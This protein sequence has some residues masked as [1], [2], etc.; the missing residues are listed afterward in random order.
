M[1]RTGFLL[2][3]RCSIDESERAASWGPPQGKRVRR[4]REELGLSDGELGEQVGLSG[5]T[6]YYYEIGLI[7]P[8]S[9]L[10]SIAEATGKPTSWF[11]DSS[12][13]EGDLAETLRSAVADLTTHESR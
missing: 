5:A 8:G 3:Y 1:P 9:F 6:I 4:A 11:L 10:P 2:R 7:D 13:P 12:E